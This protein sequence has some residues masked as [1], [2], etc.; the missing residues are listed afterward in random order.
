MMS[1]VV[2][3]SRG[4]EY[5]GKEYY[6]LLFHLPQYF[7]STSHTCTSYIHTVLKISEH[8]QLTVN[9]GLLSPILT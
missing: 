9:T 1:T 4:K 2:P 7:R 8:K 3:S 5:Y 6:G